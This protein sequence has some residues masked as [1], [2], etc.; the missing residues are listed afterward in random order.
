MSSGVEMTG[1][2]SLA[3]EGA[4]GLYE[5]F[6]KTFAEWV[7]QPRSTHKIELNL[8]T[9]DMATLRL[10]R[11]YLLCNRT[12]FIKSLEVTLSTS[13]DSIAATAE[14]IPV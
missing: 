1:D 10:H 5:K 12:W 13:S 3:I 7:R 6:H 4:N 9:E 8:S 2:L 14:I 11:K